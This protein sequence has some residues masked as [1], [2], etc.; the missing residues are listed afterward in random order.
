MNFNN[1]TIKSQEAIQQAQAACAIKP[2]AS[3]NGER[4]SLQGHFRL[5][6]KMYLPFIL[7]KLNVNVGQCSNQILGKGTRKF[8]KG[9]GW[10]KLC[11]SREARQNT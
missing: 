1:F 2:G 3:T 8:S 5:L 11:L 10:Q 6:M 7:K 9:F 4:T